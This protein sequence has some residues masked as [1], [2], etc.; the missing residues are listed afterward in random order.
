MVFMGTLSVKIYMKIFKAALC[1]AIC[2]QK[3][4]DPLA[5]QKG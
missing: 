2:S 5:V 4:P 1:F 3:G